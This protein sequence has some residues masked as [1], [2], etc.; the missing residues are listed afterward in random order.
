MILKILNKF[1]L[2]EVISNLTPGQLLIPLGI[3]S[4]RYVPAVVCD[5]SISMV[6]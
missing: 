2:N 6:L 1:A 3:I 4:D 5:P